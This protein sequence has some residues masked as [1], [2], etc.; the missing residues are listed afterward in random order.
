MIVD[1][2]A[3]FLVLKL[4]QKL[5][6]EMACLVVFLNLIYQDI[7]KKDTQKKN[8]FVFGSVYLVD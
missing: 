1:T 5:K 8:I 3:Q 4:G 6:Q 2:D 7:T